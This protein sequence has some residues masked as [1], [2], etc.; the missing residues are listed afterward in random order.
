MLFYFWVTLTHV[1]R[2]LLDQFV[3]AIF[4]LAFFYKG[5]DFVFFYQLGVRFVGGLSVG[6]RSEFFIELVFAFCCFLAIGSEDIWKVRL[7]GAECE[8]IGT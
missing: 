2:D 1:G 7:G 6:F 3:P 8:R 4:K 5:G